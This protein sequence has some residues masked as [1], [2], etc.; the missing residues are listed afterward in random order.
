MGLIILNRSKKAHILL[1]LY[2]L[3]YITGCSTPD[4]GNKI[5]SYNLQKL[6]WFIGRWKGKDKEGDFYETW[7]KINDS[8]FSG[9][10]H[11]IYDNDTVFSEV[12][13]I[14]QTDTNIYYIVNTAH[15]EKEVA[16]KLIEVSGNKAI[17]ENPAHDF[18]NRI[19]YELKNDSSLYA[20]IE[21]MSNGKEV[22]GEFN[23]KQI[24]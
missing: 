12:I 10:S 4:S 16:F 11:T 7:A 22:A 2:V 24:R 23:L 1:F 17:F 20:R 19:I 14:E 13:R 6:D 5:K 21:G 18:P 15:N 8:L 3:F 9:K